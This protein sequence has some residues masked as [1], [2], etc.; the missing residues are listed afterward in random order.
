MKTKK[1]FQSR[2]S[3]TNHFIYDL[4]L[5]CESKLMIKINKGESIQN[6]ET[7]QKLRSKDNQ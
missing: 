2:A 6:Y 1:L 3:A 4:S 5:D 7:E